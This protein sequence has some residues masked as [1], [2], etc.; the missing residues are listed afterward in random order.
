MNSI[1][2]IFVF[3]ISFNKLFS[4]NYISTKSTPTSGNICHT[5]GYVGIGTSSPEKLFHI[6]S[7]N[8]SIIRIS[9]TCVKCNYS[10][11]NWDFV[12]DNNLLF[13]YCTESTKPQTIMKLNTAGQV[14][15]GT[16]TPN[17]SALLQV[18]ST[19]MGVLIPRMNETQMQSIMLP[20]NGLL[21]FNTS[22]GKFAFY[23]VNKMIWE[24]IPTQSDLSKYLTITTFNNTIANYVTNTHLN[25]TLSYYSLSDDIANIYLSQNDF[26][27][28][29]A[30]YVTNTHLSDTLNNYLPTSEIENLFLKK[31]SNPQNTL[32]YSDNN[33]DINFLTAGSQGYFLTVDNENNFVWQDITSLIGENYWIAQ[34]D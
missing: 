9:K 21:V 18:E 19:T 11:G 23:N 8:N 31:S 6:Y 15:I 2:I 26:N 29:I 27:T 16:E 34:Q 12:N 14:L 10:I 33:G 30:N 17:N 28:T 24:F 4:Q 7:T 32:L 13:Q 1:I 22:E 5:G 25:D 20:A 3:V